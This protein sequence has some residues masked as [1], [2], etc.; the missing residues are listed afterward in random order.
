MK[1]MESLSPKFLGGNSEEMSDEKIGKLFSS[2]LDYLENVFVEDVE[3]QEGYEW[4]YQDI[5]VQ[6][7]AH[8]ILKNDYYFPLQT[9]AALE[10]LNF[11]VN[12]TENFCEVW[13]PSQ[14]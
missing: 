10:P 1:A 14:S 7:S 3:K 5:I 6:S 12:Y 2:A 13:G 8:S 9:H 11:T 4:L